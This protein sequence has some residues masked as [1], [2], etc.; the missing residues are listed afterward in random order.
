MTLLILIADISDIVT[1]RREFRAN[2]HKL[3]ILNDI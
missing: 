1:E 3:F 2:L